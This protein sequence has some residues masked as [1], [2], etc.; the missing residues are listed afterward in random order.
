[1]R[2]VKDKEG[3]HTCLMKIQIGN[4]KNNYNTKGQKI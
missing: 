4:Y 3:E 1:M 2:S